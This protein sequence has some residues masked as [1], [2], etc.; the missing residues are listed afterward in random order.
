MLILSWITNLLIEFS[1][2]IFFFNLLSSAILFIFSQNLHYSIDIALYIL[3]LYYLRQTRRERKFLYNERRPILDWVNY[4]V[5]CYLQWQ[6]WTDYFYKIKFETQ[7]NQVQII[8]L[9]LE[10]NKCKLY[11]QP[12]QNIQE[13]IIGFVWG[14]ILA[15]NQYL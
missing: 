4:R 15:W 1:L 14:L 6:C 12:K 13:F 2:V 3:F 9:N 7:F 10:F 5:Y 8:I 11:K